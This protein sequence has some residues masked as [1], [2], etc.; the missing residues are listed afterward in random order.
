[1]NHLTHNA[2]KI[3]LKSNRSGISSN[4]ITKSQN[5]NKYD[6]KFYVDKIISMYFKYDATE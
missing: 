5:E 1:M 2:Q 6:T 3:L 4:S